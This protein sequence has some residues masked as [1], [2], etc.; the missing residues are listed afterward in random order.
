MAEPVQ[1][2]YRVETVGSFWQGIKDE[3]FIALLNEWG[4]QGW[5]VVSIA[6]AHNGSRLRVVAKR[7]LSSAV[8]RQ[9]SI[10]GRY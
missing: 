8:R 6:F 5:E 1:W 4:E 3:E 7:P 9:R 2:E 10:P